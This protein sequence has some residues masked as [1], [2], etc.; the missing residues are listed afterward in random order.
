MVFGVS[1]FIFIG[2]TNGI[3][4]C[5]EQNSKKII[6]TL[7]F[8]RIYLLPT[9]ASLQG[10]FPKFVTL[11][12]MEFVQSVCWLFTFVVLWPGPSS[13]NAYEAIR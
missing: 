2:I 7:N 10:Q 8:L 4:Y 13:N 5:W 9:F 3:G 12:A 11:V 6:L 1:S